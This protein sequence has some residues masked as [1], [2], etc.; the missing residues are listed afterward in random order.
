MSDP[1]FTSHLLRFGMFE[2]DLHTGELRRKGVR[3]KLQ[4]Q[5]YQVLAHMAARP[6]VLVTRDELRERLWP[7]NTFVDFNN[8]LNIAVAKLR[9]ALGDSSEAPRFIETLPRRGY[10]FIA[11][12]E[13]LTAAP[14]V[15]AAPDAPAPP[16][17]P[18]P[19]ER[20]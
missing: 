12:V 5:P 20:G 11:P 14:A 9:D 6:G 4:E 1:G 8:S 19:V 18:P 13:Q 2:L 15:S 17:E 16:L 7:A 10:R 3:V